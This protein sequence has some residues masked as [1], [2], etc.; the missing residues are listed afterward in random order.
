MAVLLGIS[1][2]LLAVGLAVLVMLWPRGWR[3]SFSQHA[4][5]TRY[6]A[7]YYAALFIVALVPLCIF[8][9]TWLVPIFTISSALSYVFLVVCLLQV[10]CTLLP[11][12]G[13]TVGLHRWLA[14]MS[15][16]LLLLCSVLLLT[17][18][19][20]IH[21]Q[22]AVWLGIFI[23]SAVMMWLVFDRQKRVP[24]PL[25]VVYYAGFFVPV[26]IITFSQ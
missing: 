8:V 24:F 5:Q 20:S 10:A 4:S 25:Q 23:M 19:I 15:A 18:E 21:S 16:L 1:S 6:S 11:E 7:I 14:G 13:K 12:K 3:Y 9:V 2:I 17:G 26:F 22:V